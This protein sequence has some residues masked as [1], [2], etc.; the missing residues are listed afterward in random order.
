ME[1]QYNKI[2]QVITLAIVFGAALFILVEIIPALFIKAKPQNESNIPLISIEKIEKINSIL[3]ERAS[4]PLPP[5]V[6]L[7]KYNFGKAEPFR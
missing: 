1:K 5:E 2:F 7:D 6:D 3:G 4:L